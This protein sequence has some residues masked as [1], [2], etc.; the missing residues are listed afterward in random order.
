MSYGIIH[1]LCSC[2]SPGILICKSE[3]VYGWFSG[4][5]TSWLYIRMQRE[6]WLRMPGLIKSVSTES[7][8]KSKALGFFPLPQWL[9]HGTMGKDIIYRIDVILKLWLLVGRSL[10]KCNAFF[11]SRKGLYERLFASLPFSDDQE[12]FC[13]LH[14]TAHTHAT[15]LFFF[16]YSSCA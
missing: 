5:Y 4:K 8:L 3:V 15:C 7:Y 11:I 12:Y 10:C 14:S 6:T 16:T 1:L 9:K 13:I 2:W